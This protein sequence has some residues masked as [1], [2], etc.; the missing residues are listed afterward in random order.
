MKRK[1]I[2]DCDPG[3]DDAMA[4]LLAAQHFNVLGITTVNGNSHI[5]KVTKNA[6]KIV[7]FSGLTHIPV[8]QGAALPLIEPLRQNPA[9]HGLSGMDGP[10]LPEPTTALH[11]GHAAEFIIETVMANDGV[12]LVPVGPLTNIALALRLEPRIASRI[13][14]ISLMGGSTSVGNS[15]P[16]AETN[17]VIDPDAAHIVFTSGIPI[18]MAGLNITRQALSLPARMER[19]YALPGKTAKVVAGLLDWYNAKSMAAW[20][21]PGAALHDAVSVAWLID[22]TLVE[23]VTAHVAVELRGSRSRGMTVCDLRFLRLGPQ[24]SP[25]GG[26]IAGSQPPNAQVGMKLDSDRFFDLLIAAIARYQ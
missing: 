18:K 10:E 25:G 26:G 9:G 3:H 22:P 17:I 11:P 15:A 16:V 8:V 2:I 24:G 1:V 7:E 19:I 6:L 23:S 4:I 20:G 12:S 5:D 13:H 21:L 14:E